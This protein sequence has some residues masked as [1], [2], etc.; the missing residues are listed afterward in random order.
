MNLITRIAQTRICP[1]TRY[2]VLYVEP[3][4]M[5]TRLLQT[6]GALGIVG[7]GI[8]VW[9]AYQR[10]TCTNVAGGAGSCSPNVVYLVPG[11]LAALIGFSLF[12]VLYKRQSD[13]PETAGA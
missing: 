3:A 6:V 4:T 11:I 2:L 12:V 8:A 7:G 10:Q 13:G 1:S 9:Y 5:R